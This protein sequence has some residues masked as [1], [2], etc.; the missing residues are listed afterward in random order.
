[1]SV[2]VKNK[3]EFLLQTNLEKELCEFQ[4]VENKLDAM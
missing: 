1:L 2:I 4:K 3:V